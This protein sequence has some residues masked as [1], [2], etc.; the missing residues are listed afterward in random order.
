VSVADVAL[1]DVVLGPGMREMAVADLPGMEALGL[2]DTPVMLLGMD[3]LDGGGLGRV[4][5][6]KR[7]RSMYVMGP[8]GPGD[9]DDDEEEED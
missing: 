7:T 2:V 5:F 4:V 3:L 1:G 6:D 9:F 8:N